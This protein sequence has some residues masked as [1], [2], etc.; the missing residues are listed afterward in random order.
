METLRLGTFFWL[1]HPQSLFRRKTNEL[2]NQT[3]PRRN[4]MRSQGNS[5]LRLKYTFQRPS[6]PQFTEFLQHEIRRRRMNL[7]K[8]LP[9]AFFRTETFSIDQNNNIALVIFCDMHQIIHPTFTWSIR[10][11]KNVID[12]RGDV[13][14]RVSIKTE[15]C[16]MGGVYFARNNVLHRV[17]VRMISSSHTPRTSPCGHQ[18]R[19][20]TLSTNTSVQD[21]INNSKL[22]QHSL[23]LR[24]FTF[25]FI[26]YRHSSLHVLAKTFLL[27]NT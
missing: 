23:A 20:H 24:Y 3:K 5:I 1:Q 14:I 26:R 7:T 12:F 16:D 18:L 10:M 15:T 19:S 9:R 2:D 8:R 17:H 11:L 13:Q 25:S 22:G 27:V 6:Q 4:R 21:E